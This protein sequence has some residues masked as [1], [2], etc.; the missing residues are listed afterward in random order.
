MPKKLVLQE[1]IA[2]LNEGRPLRV[3]IET[4]SDTKIRRSK[5]LFGTN[6]HQ[7]THVDGND[8]PIYGLKILVESAPGVWHDALRY[9]QIGLQ[10]EAKEALKTEN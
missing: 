9:S 10:A 3:V 6:Q 7:I 1:I 2:T 4:T 5:D 8:R